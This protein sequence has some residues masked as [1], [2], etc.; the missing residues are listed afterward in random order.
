MNASASMIARPARASGVTRS[1]DGSCLARARH[2]RE[3]QHRERDAAHRKRHCGRSVVRVFHLAGRDAREEQRLRR[4][5]PDRHGAAP[6]DDDRETT[7]D[8]RPG[9]CS[10]HAASTSH[11]TIPRSATSAA[12]PRSRGARRIRIF[13][14]SVSVSASAPH[15]TMRSGG[16]EGKLQPGVARVRQ[17]YLRGQHE[18]E[19]VSCR[20]GPLEQRKIAAR[21]L[22]Q[23]AFV[24]H[25]QLEMRVR[26]VDR[27]APRLGD[28]DKR[29][30][31]R[32]ECQ[33]W[34]GPCGRA[35]RPRDHLHEVGGA[36]DKRGDGERQHERRLKEHG[37]REVAAGAHQRKPVGHL[38]RRR[39]DGEPRK[40]Q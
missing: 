6:Y 13:A 2:D 22:E 1:A 28:H 38:P 8:Q 4:D 34:V 24:D 19:P 10:A 26:V 33:C 20:G 3:E 21:V 32:T 27:L 30:R 17:E 5:Q 36:G 11:V 23:R 31:D 35:S 12:M 29:E 16:Q 37:D 40:R 39:G 18:D 7:G 25:R 14:T 15:N 9:E